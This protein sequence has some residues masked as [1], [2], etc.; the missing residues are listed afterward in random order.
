M[1]VESKYPHFVNFDF[2]PVG[3]ATSTKD[4]PNTAQYFNF[5]IAGRAIPS[6]WVTSS[7]R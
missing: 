6:S 5:W 2:G 7:R 3:K 1:N 4:S